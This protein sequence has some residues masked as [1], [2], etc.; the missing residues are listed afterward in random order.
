MGLP[1]MHYYKF[2]DIF[3][4]PISL[5]YHR[6]N[7][8]RTTLGATATY[9]LYIIMLIYGLSTLVNV[10]TGAVK[11]IDQEESKLDFH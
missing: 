4:P 10:F 6:Y 9:V 11:S 7:T 1:F 3:G 5:T 8:Y 2:H